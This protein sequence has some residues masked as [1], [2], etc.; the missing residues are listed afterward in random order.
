MKFQIKG[1]RISEGQLY[2]P[3]RIDPVTGGPSKH[4][5]SPLDHMTPEEIELEAE[6]L[7]TLFNQLQE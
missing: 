3:F 6:K 4:Q 5:E 1:V 7:G 2:L